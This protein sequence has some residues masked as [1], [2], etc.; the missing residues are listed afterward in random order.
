MIPIILAVLIWTVEAPVGP[1]SVQG[2]GIVPPW[3]WSVVEDAEGCFSNNVFTAPSDGYLKTV[4]NAG[5]I[6]G[7]LTNGWAGMSIRT[8]SGGV[9]FQAVGLNPLGAVRHL[10]T[11]WQGRIG[12]GDIVNVRMSSVQM[13]KWTGGPGFL[14]WTGEFKPMIETVTLAD[15]EL[16]NDPMKV[17]LVF[18]V[19]AFFGRVV[20]VWLKSVGKRFRRMGGD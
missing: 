14:F 13:S 1:T 5:W 4:F 12:S 20:K 11:Y 18:F 19:G 3:S 2:T 16:G 6:D 10:Q 7:W 9:V 8:N 15:M 17:F